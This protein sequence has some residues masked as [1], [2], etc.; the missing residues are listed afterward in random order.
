MSATELYSKDIDLY[1]AALQRKPL[2]CK[3]YKDIY[4]YIE[5]Q[6]DRGAP[7]SIIE[8]GSGCGFI[9][10][11]IKDCICTDI[12]E[13]TGVDY[14]ENIYALSNR[15]DQANT[16]IL[17]DVLHHLQFPGSA[18]QQLHTRL[19]P[20]G[21]VILCEPYMSVF[22]AIVF[23]LFHHEPVGFFKP[24]EWFSSKNADDAQDMY[25]AAESNPTRIFRSSKYKKLLEEHWVVR[26]TRIDSSW[27]YMASGGFR[28]AQLYPTAWYTFMK[29]IDK[30]LSI[31]PRIFGT[32]FFVVLEKR[33]IN[34]LNRNTR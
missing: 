1:H 20:G 21:R 3:I 11:V 27:S 23:M 13:A 25:Y 24:I 14:V 34:S 6:I 22:S 16:F 30:L 2:L 32:R 7:G 19:A 15:S 8:I 33:E 5:S 26:I 10:S 12:V 17:V 29:K 4:A 31:F 9:K 18:L 28:K